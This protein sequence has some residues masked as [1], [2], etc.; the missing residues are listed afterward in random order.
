M[1]TY[2]LI[3]IDSGAWWQQAITYANVDLSSKVFCGIHL[4]AISQEELLNLIHNMCS[5]NKVLTLAYHQGPMS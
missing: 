4:R 1:V 3:N 2:I 5:E